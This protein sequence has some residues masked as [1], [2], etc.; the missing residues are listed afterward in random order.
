M[1]E[2]NAHRV[3]EIEDGLI[4][5]RFSDDDGNVRDINAA[6]LAEV[7]Q[8]LVEFTAG[9]SKTGM[10]GNG[11]PPE[12]RV[13]P[14]KQGSFIVEAILQWAGANP[15]ATIGLATTAGGAIVQ[16]LNVGIKRLRGTEP[17]N[18]EYLD[19][20]Q[21]KVQ[22][23]DNTVDEISLPAWK[24]LNEMKRP[25]RRTLRK[26]LA[27]LGDD[28]DRVE[29]RD[30]RADESTEQVLTTEPDVVARREDYLSAAVEV[31]EVDEN[32]DILEVEG[33]LSS[34]DFRPGQKWRVQTPLGTRMATMEDASFLAEV[35]RGLALHKTDNFRL[36]IRQERVVTNGRTKIDW[37]VV[38]VERARLGDSADGQHA[39][40]SSA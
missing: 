40:P 16:S 12:V 8:G 37:A 6:E 4:Q 32:T 28:V 3:D 39:E 19:N 38:R 31:D 33:Q 14:P 29:V 34:I 23:P 5:L 15:E 11:V 27:P 22:W 2:G 35:D 13:R 7:L 17:S 20:G 10:L 30:G 1:T 24:K 21:V 9:M 18:F 25:T 26:I 36:R